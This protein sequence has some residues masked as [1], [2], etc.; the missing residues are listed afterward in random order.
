MTRA[1]VVIV[2]AGFAGFHCARRLSKLA[3]S[4][5]AITVINPTDYFLYLPLLPQVAGGLLNPTR[6][7]VPLPSTLPNVRLQLGEARDIDID[8]RTVSYVDPEDN[9]S[10][11]SYD[12]LVLAA[13]SVN[14]LLPIPG[15]ADHAHGFRGIPEALFLRE[16]LTR[17]VE[18]AENADDPKERAA[19]L[20][21]IVVGAGYTGTE[22]LVHGQKLVASI[23]KT[24]PRLRGERAK[25]YLLD[26]ADRVLPGL[27]S[28]M[29]RT[30]ERVL[31][32]RGVDVRMGCSVTEA[33]AE[34]AYLSDRS[35]VSSRTLI[36][37]V[38]VRPDPFIEA[39]GLPTDKGR[40]IVHT[41]L[42]VPDHPEIYAVGDAAAVPDLTMPGQTTAMTAQHAQRQGQ[43]A[44]ENIVATLTRG[45]RR[46]YRHHDLGFTV[47]LAGGAAAADPLHIPL[48]GLP[49]FAV[50]SGYHLLA[51]PAGRLGVAADWAIGAVTRRQPVQLGLVSAAN[52][53]LDTAAPELPGRTA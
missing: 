39:T 28:R 41:D 47:D 52:V 35:F 48:S 14:K 45:S 27:A 4:H 10:E 34:G 51:L 13:G 19:R 12:L 24:R 53:P 32:R 22:V 33:T 26:T 15:I 20:T 30:A 31:A 49:A 11:I 5:I 43:L 6:V 38:G 21:F 23:L 29:S 7:A 25:W 40:L 3:G 37:C 16:H 44:A 2:G 17:Q 50:T 46:A 1:R 36:W 8:R 9:A 42:T 18:M